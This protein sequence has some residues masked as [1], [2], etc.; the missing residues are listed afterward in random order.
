MSIIFENSDFV[1]DHVVVG[2]LANNVFTIKCTQTGEGLLI[3]AA[4]EDEFLSDIC[5]EYGVR[6]VL[7]THGHFDHIG[8][9]ATLRDKGIE[10][11]VHELDS[12]QLPSYDLNVEHGKII[13]VGKLKFDVIHTPGHTPGS[14]SLKLKNSP[15][16]FTGD[17]L[18]P[19][20]PGATHFPGGDFT[21]IMDSIESKL[22]VFDKET[23]V[24]PGHG[25]STTV[26][27][28]RPSID[29]WA[30]RGW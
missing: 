7:T 8:A 22:M 20:G 16:L 30:S 27:Q 12:S 11:W 2:P 14:L 17:T 1:L 13:E 24:L 5:K 28:E 25:S 26:G 10:I 29:A 3:D 15:F 18:F 6:R 21:T 9:V 4:D 23:I 19:G